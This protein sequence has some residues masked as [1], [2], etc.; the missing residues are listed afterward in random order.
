MAGSAPSLSGVAPACALRVA[1][2]TELKRVTEIPGG[3]QLLSGGQVSEAFRL[4][5]KEWSSD[6]LAGLTLQIEQEFL[7]VCPSG[8]SLPTLVRELKQ[9]YLQ[10][11]GLA[12]A[13]YEAKE[14]DPLF[15]GLLAKG[16]D[17]FRIGNA[18]RG[19][20]GKIT[21][22]QALTKVY[23]ASQLHQSV[24][25]VGGKGLGQAVRDLVSEICDG[26]G[27]CAFW[28]PV[29]LYKVVVVPQDGLAGYIPELAT[30]A[31]SERLFSEPTR[32]HR[33]VV[34]HELA[35][36]ASSA[37]WYRERREWP[38]EFAKL[39]GWKVSE[40]KGPQ[41]TVRRGPA[42]HEDQLTAQSAHSAF[43]LL[44]DPIVVPDNGGDGFVTGRSYSESQNQG[45]V[46]E[47]LCDHIAVFRY[48]PERF[49]FRGKPLAPLKYE[50]IRKN[51][52]PGAPP[53]QC[54]QA[55]ISSKAG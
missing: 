40:T 50:W 2:I 47:D 43:S 13:R 53:L 38:E 16:S 23:G 49:C 7:S 42:Q 20:G 24:A 18:L 21:A 37:A 36:A 28:D 48:A 6:L 54:D 26:S 22:K 15:R 51:V 8:T 55:A 12:P 34:L 44:P 17:H 5:I 45:H 33:V 10:K 11:L 35:H 32:L 9:A 52:F 14:L 41:L 30:L 4:G 27:P 25:I 1:A 29:A 3:N 19:L 31:V 46:S 39:S